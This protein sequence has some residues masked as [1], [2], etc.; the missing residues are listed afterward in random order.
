MTAPLHPMAAPKGILRGTFLFLNAMI[1][2]PVYSILYYKI[3]FWSSLYYSVYNNTYLL[4]AIIAYV[5]YILLDKSSYNGGWNVSSRLQ[6]WLNNYAG[7]RYLAEYFDCE[8]IKEKDLDPSKQ[9]VFVYH[10]HGIIAV[11]I[12]ASLGTNGA[13]FDK[14]F[15]GV[16]EMDMCTKL[17]VMM[18]INI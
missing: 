8:L 9:Y 18:P 11:G 2:V 6:L 10:P 12:C 5:L 7:F 17:T 1:T 3:L 14:H 13:N 4:T 16:S 15:P